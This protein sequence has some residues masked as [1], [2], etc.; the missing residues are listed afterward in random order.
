[1][2]EPVDKDKQLAVEP[3]QNK[4]VELLDYDPSEQSF[5]ST[6]S[7]EGPESS[8]HADVRGN[9][10]KIPHC[11]HYKTKGHPIEVCHAEMYCDIC[12]SHDHV[13]PRCPKFRAS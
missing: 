5:K 9:S 3:R 8:K 12:A 7:L 10:G 4:G 2:K 1:M 13:H 6:A 11:Y